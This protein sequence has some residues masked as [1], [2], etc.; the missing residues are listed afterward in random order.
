MHDFH[1][2]HMRIGGSALQ[3]QHCSLLDNAMERRGGRRRWGLGL[4]SNSKVIHVGMTL[5]GTR[6]IEAS[7]P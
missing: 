3:G 5:I 7:R 6:H 2:S 4:L 1:E